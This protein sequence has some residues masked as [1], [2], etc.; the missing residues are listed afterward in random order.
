MDGNGWQWIF[1]LD[2][3]DHLQSTYG[4]FNAMTIW[5]QRSSLIEGAQLQ[6]FPLNEIRPWSLT[7][8]LE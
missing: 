5:A 4:F 2:I 1:Q 7:T 3:F 6:P 8:A